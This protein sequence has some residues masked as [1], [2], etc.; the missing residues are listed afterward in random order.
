VIG[1]NPYVLFFLFFFNIKEWRLAGS[2][3]SMTSHRLSIFVRI[4]VG[5]VPPPSPPADLTAPLDA[6][7]ANSPNTRH[8]H[9]RQSQK[10]DTDNNH[11]GL[12]RTASLES[13]LTSAIDAVSGF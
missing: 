4:P 9:T 3:S 1:N 12:N 8:L 6:R 11:R 13:G 10:V 5:V 7:A 2:E